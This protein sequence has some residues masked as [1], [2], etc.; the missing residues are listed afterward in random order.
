MLGAVVRD[1][2]ALLTFWFGTLTNGCADEDHRSRWFQSN[3]AFDGQCRDQWAPLL[4]EA[5]AG[6][7]EDWLIHARGKLAYVV[8]CDQMPRN[9]YRG[10]ADAYAWDHL[11]LAAARSAVQLREDLALAWDERSFLYMP[12]EHA[13]NVIDQHTAV[14]LFSALR[15]QSPREVRNVTGNYL[16]YAQLHRD[17]VLRF[18]RFP[19]RNAVLG[20]SSSEEERQF[21]DAGDGFGQSV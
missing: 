3:E 4:A 1:P 19:H 10:Q 14:G 8:L 21:V 18:G 11:A 9:V 12:F 6:K 17:I 15:D 5:R 20:R 7:L 2:E 16:R 13:E